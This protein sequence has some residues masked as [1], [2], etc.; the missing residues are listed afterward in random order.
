MKKQARRMSTGVAPAASSARHRLSSGYATSSDAM[1]SISKDSGDLYRDSLRGGP[2]EAAR[3]HFRLAAKERR[4]GAR[5]R[6]QTRATERRT[7]VD[8]GQQG[9]KTG[10]EGRRWRREAGPESHPRN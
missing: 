1:P 9:K 5:T 8:R 6:R 4:S 10:K 7:A 3:R 2:R